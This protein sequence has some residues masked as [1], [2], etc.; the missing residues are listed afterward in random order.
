MEKMNESVCMNNR[1]TLNGGGKRQVKKVHK[2]R[3]L[4]MYWVFFI[5][6][7]QWINKGTR[8]KSPELLKPCQ[9]Y[10]TNL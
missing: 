7:Y 3:V 1:V 10:A 6:C 8:P 2:A 5:G 4:E 9:G